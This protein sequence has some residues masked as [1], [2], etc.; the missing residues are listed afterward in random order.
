MRRFLLA[1]LAASAPSLAA[2]EPPVDLALVLAM[3][4]SAS[5]TIDRYELQRDGFAAAFRS[6][7]VAEA[8]T[9]GDR[10]A[11]AVTL[12]EW[13]GPTNQ[14]QVIGWTILTSAASANAF[15]AALA[16]APRAF[17]DFT[18]ISAAVDFSVRLLQTSSLDTQRMVIDVSGDGSNNSGRPLAAARDDA[19]AAGVTVNGLAILGN[20]PGLDGYYRDNVIGGDGAFMIVAQDFSAFSDAILK[21]LVREIA[22]IPALPFSVALLGW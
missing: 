11:I 16:E 18:S 1:V 12:V 4:V 13:S 6:A 22:V 15:G 10:H 7:A 2:A 8:I 21:K 5:V 9:S 14:A 19:I 20:E 3:D 17:S